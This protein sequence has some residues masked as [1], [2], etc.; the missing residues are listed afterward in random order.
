MRG[1]NA[2]KVH[3]AIFAAID[4][5]GTSEP[6]ENISIRPEDPSTRPPVAET[7]LRVRSCDLFIVVLWVDEV[8]YDERTGQTAIGHEI[9]EALD[10]GKSTLAYIDHKFF[11]DIRE[12]RRNRERS[13]WPAL[14]ELYLKAAQLMDFHT[15]A[16][17]AEFDVSSVA[18]DQR[19][20]E[21][22]VFLLY[23]SV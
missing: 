15:G 10:G 3:D 4:A 13:D 23:G 6:I 14:Y 12:L 7:R 2:R 17:G 16:T 1:E 8:F 21:Q 9:S 18:D 11:D 20:F 5:V 19:S 22:R